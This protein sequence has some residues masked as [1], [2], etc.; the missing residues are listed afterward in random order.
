MQQEDTPDFARGSWLT[1]T[2]DHGLDEA[3]RSFVNRF[4]CRPRYVALDTRFPVVTIKAGPVP[5]P[6]ID[7]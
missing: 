5:E 3:K 1:F 2:G 4:Q 6:E 7:L